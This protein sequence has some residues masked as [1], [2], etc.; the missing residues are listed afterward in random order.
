MFDIVIGSGMGFITASSLGYCHSTQIQPLELYSKLSK[1]VFCRTAIQKLVAHGKLSSLYDEN[2]LHDL[3]LQY[4]GQ[5]LSLSSA[6]P[7]LVG[8]TK[9]NHDDGA[10]LIRS[11]EAKDAMLSPGDSRWSVVEAIRACIANSMYLPPYENG[12]DVYRSAPAIFSNPTKLL[13]EEV[14]ELLG[15][16]RLSDYVDVVVT[17]GPGLTQYHVLG[18]V[19]M[20]EGDILD[21]VM[22]P[23]FMDES[24][25]VEFVHH[26]MEQL[27]EQEK[28]DGGRSFEYFYFNPTLTIL[29]KIAADTFTLENFRKIAEATSGT[30]EFES[31][32]RKLMGPLPIYPV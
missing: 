6:S 4:F 16:R 31:L 15:T 22:T 17:L 9:R 18:D 25:E 10:F 21:Q 27:Q 30:A 26:Q 11:Y 19:K 29:H 20:V 2:A 7:K 12:S 14:Q 8:V 24:K 23:S 5:D 1:E 13:I 32:C 28:K 3:L